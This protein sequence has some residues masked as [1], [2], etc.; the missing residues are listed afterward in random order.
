MA[1]QLHKDGLIPEIDYMY[2]LLAAADRVASAAMWLAVHMTYARN[3]YLDGRDLAQDD[4]KPDPEGH[5]GGVLNM[6]PAYVGYLAAN[7][8]T[9]TT[10]SWLMGQGHCV[11]AIDST[12]LLVANMTT[13]HAERYDI[14]DAGL[15]RFVRDFYSYVVR[16]DGRPD[17]PL[18]SHVNAH[19]AGGMMEG[20]YLGFAELQYAHMPLPGESLVTFLSDGAFEEQ[21][22]SDWTPRWWRAKD[23][24]LITPF[25]ILN[26]RRI[27]QRSSMAMKGGAGWLNKH[28]QL[29]GFTPLYTDGRDP[30]SFA[31]GVIEMETRLKQAADAIH[32]GEAG[33][34]APIY[35]GIAETVKGY[36]F[37]GAGTNRAHNL[38]LQG[39]PAKDAAARDE[40]NTGA[41]KLRVPAAEVDEAVRMLNQHAVQDRPKERD[42]P[43]AHRQIPTPDLPEPPWQDPGP[44]EAVSA[45]RGIDAYFCNIVEANPELRV[46]VG[47]P[48]EMRSN[49]LDKTLD[50][51]KHRVTNPEAGIAEDSHGMVIT[52]LNEEAVV[53]AALANKGGLNLVAS[54]EAFAVKML[55]A[56]R[57]ELIFSRH[58]HENGRPPGWLSVPIIPTSHTWENGKNEQSHQD[59]TFCEALLG[60]MSDVSR[61]LFPADWNSAIAAL[62]ATYSTHGQIW[63]LV[64]PKRPLPVFFTKQ[65]AQQLAEQG[66]IRL[67]GSGHEEERLQLVASG[68]YQLA[69]VLKASER[70]E[71]A[72]IEHAVIYLQEPGRFRMPRD[73]R[74]MEFVAPQE[75]IEDLFPNT[76][77]ARVFVTHTRPGALIG[78]I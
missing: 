69:E 26:G 19:T 33:Y 29:N 11:A 38:P 68:G 49:R 53:S 57:Q 48:D 74:E 71:H 43:L 22:G 32:N 34:P 37:P 14:S 6:I 64:I 17:S 9:G 47:N 46:R 8:L 1:H 76:T 78:T 21:R 16:P 20:G 28:L 42:H 3:V 45:M 23:C 13:A 5:T 10:R 65:Q 54:Y 2:R 75:V 18:G 30:A 58:L 66:A 61:V 25:M 67:R 73:K 15:T 39:N 24:G 52:A 41:R 12:N 77:T 40:F 70:L 56:I 36:G 72:G 44:D 4:F 50:L 62:R 59:P 31:W 55:G 63:T 7:S 60:E 27:D 51:L 35:Y